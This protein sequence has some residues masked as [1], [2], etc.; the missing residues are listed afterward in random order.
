MFEA[1]AT[2][3]SALV[4][5]PAMVGATHLLMDQIEQL[6]A[7]EDKKHMNRLRL[8]TQ[9]AATVQWEQEEGCLTIGLS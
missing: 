3:S 6:Q 9:A 4:Q 2:R 5:G 7:H 8:K 1:V